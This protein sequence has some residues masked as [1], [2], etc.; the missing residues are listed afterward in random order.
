MP[1]NVPAADTDGK[2]AQKICVRPGHLSRC[3]AMKYAT[4]MVTR[5]R[6]R[7]RPHLYIKEHLRAR[8][9]SVD[10]VAG[11]LGMTRE[12]TYRSIREQ[13]RIGYTEISAWAEAIGLERWQDLT[14]PPGEPS[15]DARI[16]DIPQ[17]LRDAVFRLVGRA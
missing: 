3:G 13:H 2:G 10:Q 1:V 17:E 11:R 12:S 5:I 8:G 14:R 16:D 6:G 9:L 7:A 15:I 4:G